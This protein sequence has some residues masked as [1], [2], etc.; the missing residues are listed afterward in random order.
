MSG[1]RQT[2]VLSCHPPPNTQAHAAGIMPPSTAASAYDT[3]SPGITFRRTAKL[4]P[5]KIY[6]PLS[7]LPSCEMF[8]HF[9][10]DFHDVN[11]C[12]RNL[13][14]GQFPS[15][16]RGIDPSQASVF[17]ANS[18]TVGL[19]GQ[20]SSSSKSSIISSISSISSYI[21]TYKSSSSFSISSNS[22]CTSSLSYRASVSSIRFCRESSLS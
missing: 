16:N 12:G 19:T 5:D 22:S 1:Y 9:V 10:L 2:S 3:K 18:Q 8:Y 14:F 17:V 13:Y 7:V 20:K 4:F 6:F 15:R 21:S 11:T